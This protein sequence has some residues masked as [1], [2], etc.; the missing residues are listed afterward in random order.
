[1]AHWQ[2]IFLTFALLL[3]QARA[4]NLNKPSTTSPFRAEKSGASAASRRDALAQ[5]QAVVMMGTSAT[6]LIAGPQ[7]AQASGGATA[8][9]Y[10]TIPIAKRRYYGRV[11][12]GVHEFLLMAPAMVDQDMT[13]YPI[14]HF[15]DPEGTVIV[16][17][18]RKDV[19]GQC[20][21]KDGDCKGK[22]IRDSRW[23]DMKA[24]MYL[25]ANAFRTD[26][27][28]PPDRLPTVKAAR[29][30]FKEV[31]VMQKNISKKKKKDPE[32]AAIY[33]AALDLLDSY[34]DLVELPPLDSGHYDKDF[35]TLVG[36]T[37]R[38]T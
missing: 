15:F 5:M 2:L 33:V 6:A 26:Q 11:Q 30:F 9:R 14:Q 25:L 29:A 32:T 19:N 8:G 20:T 12:Q 35:D 24:S 7:Q 3:F 4:Y 36:E 13:S 1:M 10:T 27:Q 31:D 16:E 23:N 17:A 28:K 34:L 18:K 37:A 38:L 22:E 21:K